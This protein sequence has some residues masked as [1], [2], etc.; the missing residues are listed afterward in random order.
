LA[1][2]RIADVDSQRML[3]HIR[4]GKGRKDRDLMLPK[5]AGRIPAALSQAA[6]KASRVAGSRWALAHRRLPIDAKVVWY[7]F[8]EVVRRAGIDKPMHP[9]TLFGERNVFLILGDGVP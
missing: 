1:N 9:Q 5:P 6:S 2:L 4:G 7:T 8:R 3:I